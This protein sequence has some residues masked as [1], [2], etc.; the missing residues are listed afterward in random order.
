MINVFLELILQP[1]TA[2]FIFGSA[3]GLLLSVLFGFGGRPRKAAENS[4]APH[5]QLLVFDQDTLV[6]ACENARKAISADDIEDGL[7]VSLCQRLTEAFPQFSRAFETARHE[8]ARFEL[9]DITT[10]GPISVDVRCE[11]TVCRFA[12]TGL[13]DLMASRVLIDRA[14][15]DANEQEL[16][17][18]RSTVATGPTIIWREDKMGTIDW[19]NSTY[20]GVVEQAHPNDRTNWPPNRLF[21]GAT[22]TPP[23]EVA[24]SRRSPL[25]LP[26]GSTHWFDVTSY[27]H[28]NMTLHY[29]TDISRTVHAEESLRNFMQTLTQTFAALPIGLAI[30]D[31]NRQLQLF[32]PALMDLTTLEPE[33]LATR[34]TLYDFI[35]G[36][37]EKRMLPER[38]DFTDWRAKINQLN[39][40]AIDGTYLETWALPTGQTYKVT[41]RPHPEGAIA[42][43]IEDVSSEVSLTRRFRQELELSQSMFDNLPEAIA[44]FDASGNLALTNAA[45]SDLWGTDPELVV[46]QTGIVEATRHWQNHSQPAPLWG[47]ARE[48]VCH[49]GERVEW[50]GS[51]NMVDGS[52]LSCRFKPLAG[53]ATMVSFTRE[54]AEII[55]QIPFRRLASANI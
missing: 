28:G 49:A 27:G 32:N 21:E 23:G 19:V 12:I 44:V 55:P 51:A 10:S 14:H 20:L 4:I 31:R 3:F 25:I 5:T 48:F 13:P 22:I 8:S 50:F 7:L 26:D 45:Y 46:E 40:S 15:N 33:W 1:T 9:S 42:F 54:E 47:D 16:A 43:L 36:L 34:P 2:I 53:G 6:S 17:I 38:K 18:L 11:G 39:K 52:H 37:R 24:R 35:N 41:G 30:F 29:A